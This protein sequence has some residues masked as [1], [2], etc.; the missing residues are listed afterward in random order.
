MSKI[1]I[2]WYAYNND[3]V[4]QKHPTLG[5]K[6]VGIDEKGT[7]FSFHKHFW[8]TGNYSKHILLNGNSSKSDK[9]SFDLLVSELQKHFKGHIIEKK[10]I[11]INSI[12]EKISN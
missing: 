1:L 12:E 3:F 7:T 8:E 4:V 10:E 6:I 2:S 9:E 11:E 5:R